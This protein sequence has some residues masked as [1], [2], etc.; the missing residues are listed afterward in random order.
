MKLTRNLGWAMLGFVATGA[1]LAG[2]A[3]AA[4]PEIKTLAAADLKFEDAGAGMRGG[5]VAPLWGD[6][7]KSAHASVFRF[8]S[9]MS[10]PVHSHA[11]E[12]QGVVIS[13]T[14]QM[15]SDTQTQ[16]DTKPLG[17]GSYFVI[18][19]GYKYVAACVPNDECMVYVT[20]KAKWDFK[21]V[22]PPAEKKDT[23]KP[24]AKPAK[25]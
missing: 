5:K 4:A 1:G 21:P 6:F 12:L 3:L 22:M 25:K 10:T 23:D 20:Q 8:P 18:P 7:K 14:F 19:P 16:K 15:W 24:A 11:A 2:R 17:P 9:Q 13:G